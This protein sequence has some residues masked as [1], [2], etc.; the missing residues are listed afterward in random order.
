M[1]GAPLFRGQ[2]V[3]FTTKPSPEQMLEELV[4]HSFNWKPG[5]PHN[6]PNF[7]ATTAPCC[8]GCTHHKRMSSSIKGKSLKKYGYYGKCSKAGGPE[9]CK[10][11]KGDQRG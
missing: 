4:Q 2:E 10:P 7:E 8:Q 5:D 6:N 3:R 1:I 9:K 11:M